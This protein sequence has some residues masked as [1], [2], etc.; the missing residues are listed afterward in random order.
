MIGER[1]LFDQIAEQNQ[2]IMSPGVLI[3]TIE[4]C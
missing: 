2:G 1:E 4:E 3:V